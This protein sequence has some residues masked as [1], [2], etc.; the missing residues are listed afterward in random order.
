LCV[1]RR[2]A[3][4]GW[5]GARN[6][7]PR[8]SKPTPPKAR[9]ATPGTRVRIV[10]V[11]DHPMVRERLADLI[12]REPDLE[13]CGEAEGRT[14]AL[15][16]I[17][18]RHPRLAIIDLSLK[19]AFGLE[20]IHDLRVSHPRLLLLVLTMHES[21]LYAERALRAGASGYLTKRDAT[22]RI[23]P[24]IRQVLAGEIYLSESLAGRVAG[25]VIRRANGSMES[26][27]DRELDVL[28]RLGLGQNTRDIATALHL[29]LRTVETYRARIK[30]KLNLKDAFDLVRFAIEWSKEQEGA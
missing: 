29:D 10:L 9:A 1:S 27:S 15:S 4:L 21:P 22:T 13:V 16:V 30:T 18:T 24:A 14:D 2:R 25:Q 3:T 28:R 17:A 6:K 20:L 8:M 19:D 5:H 11:D 7:P 12:N 26:L 23:L